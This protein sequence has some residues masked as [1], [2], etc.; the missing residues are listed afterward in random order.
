[1]KDSLVIE[2]S[3]VDDRQ[4]LIVAI[5]NDEFGKGFMKWF[6]DDLPDTHS[7]FRNI[8]TKIFT[9]F[10]WGEY[11]LNKPKDLI[12]KS[13]NIHDGLKV[14]P[15][16]PEDEIKEIIGVYGASNYFP[17]GLEKLLE[18]FP[19]ESRF[20]RKTEYKIT[21]GLLLDRSDRGRVR[22][23]LPDV[24]VEN[25]SDSEELKSFEMEIIRN[26]EEVEE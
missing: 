12:G 4:H 10:E 11:G 23:W 24:I 1:M 18:L 26:D 6:D 7:Y 25:L 3:C 14:N 5:G 9:Q 16:Y 13:I 2:C 20:Y 22:K 19:N 17:K 8:D 15:D 21:I